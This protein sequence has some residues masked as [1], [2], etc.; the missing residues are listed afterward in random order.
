MRRY[1]RPDKARTRRLL[2]RYHKEGDRRARE[3]VIQEQLPLVE[4]LARKFAGRGEPVD[5]L[6]QVASVGLIKAVD[7]FDV[8]R[9]IEF[10]T[11]AT[12][13][14]LGEIKR[15]F[16]DKGWAMRVPRGLQELRQ[17]AKEAIR[18]E[19]VS[20]GRSPTIQEL[21]RILNADEESVAE[22]L[23]LGRAYNTNSLDA[24]VNQDDTDGDTIVDLQ[25][26]G[27]SPID[28]I[29]DKLLLR[30]A[31]RLLKDQQQTILKL[32]FDEG[33]TQTEIA[34]RIGV[35]QMHVSRLLRRAI[36]DLRRELT[37]LEN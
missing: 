22:A 31:M 29:E 23:T 7:R 27:D 25:A 24:P 18:D 11:Y 30:S 21:S 2:V 9:Q 28:G 33:K 3:R 5:D 1:R 35:S 13:N 4:F 6:V 37:E 32:R 12:P 10:S 19:T 36:E 8:D 14:I 34:D 26:D 16:R 17:S 20:S 15:Y